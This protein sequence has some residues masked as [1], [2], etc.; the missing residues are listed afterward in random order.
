MRQF[1]ALA[2][3]PAALCLASLPTEAADQAAANPPCIGNTNLPA[4]LADKFEA[5]DD[6]QLLSAA[7][8][9]TPDAGNLCQGK[10]YQLKPG[11]DITVFRA[12][13]STNPKSKFGTWWA[14]QMPTGRVADYRA[15]YEICYQWSPLDKLVKCH[16]KPGTKIVLGTGQSAKCSEYLTYPVSDKQQVYI[17][18][19][20]T[21]HTVCKEFDGVFRW[22]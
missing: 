21:A 12:W 10:V 7:V 2:L 14:F 22:K 1:V 17:A 5:V 9:T 11:D 13:N 3:F 15:G 4:D 16:L 19:S 18:D 6:P 8:N 20:A